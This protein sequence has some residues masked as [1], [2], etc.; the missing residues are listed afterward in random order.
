M[1]TILDGS[2]MVAAL[3]VTVLSGTQSACD[4]TRYVEYFASDALGNVYNDSNN[5]IYVNNPSGVSSLFIRSVAGTP[6]EFA[7]I[8]GLAFDASG[9]VY[10]AD[11]AKNKIFKVTVAG[12]IS[13]FAGTGVSGFADGPSTTAQ[14]AAP[15]GLAIDASGNLY[16]ATNA[17]IR[18]ISNT[19][20][21][22]TLAGQALSGYVDGPASVAKFGAVYSIVVDKENNILLSDATNHVIRKITPAGVTS[23]FAGTGADG[24]DDGTV[25]TATFRWPQGMA[26]NANGDLFVSDNYFNPGRAS[27]IRMINKAGLV[28]TFMNG[29]FSTPQVLPGPLNVA[30]VMFPNGL[31]F[32]AAGDMYIAQTGNGC[33][34]IVTFN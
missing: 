31:A 19:G 14:L 17:R 25:K 21:I 3:D 5:S 30:S 10:F 8:S 28:T 15:S 32:N 11:R 27:K 23:T 12:V 6:G 20:E 1:I 26:F 24:W 18:K 9:N 29:D 16:T 4:Y 13:T 7:V 33:R 22:S 2:A 34:T